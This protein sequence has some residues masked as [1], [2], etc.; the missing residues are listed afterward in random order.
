VLQ[1]YDQLKAE[2]FTTEQLA[3]VYAPMGL[4]IGSDSPAEI[5]VSIVAEILM[6][7]RGKSGKPLKI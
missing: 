2:G 3:A 1:V 5:A 6:V 7:L 4:D